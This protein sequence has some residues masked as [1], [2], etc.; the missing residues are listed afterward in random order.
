M[1]QKNNTTSD[2]ASTIS[3]M[4]GMGSDIEK[5]IS[6]LTGDG[7]EMDEITT[8]LQELGYSQTDLDDAYSNMRTKAQQRRAE[9]QRLQDMYDQS[10]VDSDGYTEDTIPDERMAQDGFETIDPVVP[11]VAGSG[12]LKGRK[13]LQKF[14]TPE[15]QASVNAGAGIGSIE[16]NFAN[17]GD[18][19]GLTEEQLSVIN[20]PDF[21]LNPTAYR[22]QVPGKFIRGQK[23]AGKAVA[24]SVGR[25]NLFPIKYPKGSANIETPEVDLYAES[26]PVTG[27]DYTSDVPTENQSGPRMKRQGA[28]NSAVNN[29]FANLA[30]NKGR[31]KRQ[32]SNRT[33]F[34]KRIKEGGENMYQFGGAPSYFTAD[35]FMSQLEDDGV[36]YG[37][38]YSQYLPMNL[39]SRSS[40]VHVA[41]FLASAIGGLFSGKDRDDDGLMDGF[42]RDIKA[43]KLKER[44]YYKDQRTSEEKGQDAL[45]YSRVDFD[46]ETGQYTGF[47][48]DKDPTK[49]LSK[50]RSIRE[51]ALEELNQGTPLGEFLAR[52]EDRPDLVQGILDYKKGVRSGDV[53]KGT[54]YG[55][56]ERGAEGYYTGENPYFYDT[57]MGLNPL[58]GAAPSGDKVDD[59]AD[60]EKL[61]FDLLELENAPKIDGCF[62]GNCDPDDQIE[63]LDYKP[64][65]ESANPNLPY[66]YKLDETSTSPTSTSTMNG[67][68]TG[69]DVT[70]LQEMY[71]DS[72]IDESK[73]TGFEKENAAMENRMRALQLMQTEAQGTMPNN[74]LLGNDPNA[75]RKYLA[76]MNYN[77]DV[78]LPSRGLGEEAVSNII[79]SKTYDDDPTNDNLEYLLGPLRYVAAGEGVPRKGAMLNAGQGFGDQT[80]TGFYGSDGR[81]IHD[82]SRY[83]MDFN[84]KRNINFINKFADK[85]QFEEDYANDPLFEY[86]EGRNLP[87]K[88][89]DGKEVDPP[90]KKAFELPGNLIEQTLFHYNNHAQ[91]LRELVYGNNFTTALNATSNFF[92]MGDTDMY[93]DY[94]KEYSDH[95][96]NRY[97]NLAESLGHLRSNYP[98]RY[99]KDYADYVKHFGKEAFQK[100]FFGTS[101]PTANKVVEMDWMKKMQNGGGPFDIDV[102]ALKQFMATYPD[103]NQLQEAFSTTGDYADYRGTGTGDAMDD[104]AEDTYNPYPLGP[105]TREE[106]KEAR[107]ERRENREEKLMNFRRKGNNFLDRMI[108]GRFGEGMAKLG[109]L[110]VGAANII[111]QAAENARASQAE[112]DIIAL[113]MSDRK[114]VEFGKDR[115]GTDIQGG[116]FGDIMAG[117]SP[118]GFTN[119]M[120]KHG[121]ELN[122]STDMIAKLIAAGADIEIK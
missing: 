99:A 82:A 102:N 80:A 64:I 61:E 41:P 32:Y 63:S 112:Q 113:G 13:R 65:R 101:T 118:D 7:Y 37:D 50:K 78:G 21:Q 111:N 90:S 95:E 67:V 10:V 115:T 117:D 75:I 69:D 42:F 97:K 120:S 94:A 87:I 76:Q 119:T 17:L 35:Q 40:P 98:D 74:P 57:M 72:F 6:E 49:Y 12:V 70:R 51:K 9:M 24:A 91:A 60:I 83:G 56:D 86:Y 105:E 71:P 110:G 48:T 43:K 33:Y 92:G 68:V 59:S 93:A 38:P 81:P 20:N 100:S 79:A 52:F 1:S 11:P 73:L 62:G 14:L 77:A 58:A 106:R 15:A 39:F 46:P 53:P 18:T 22:G 107:Q 31:G 96:R 3:T 55:I 8:A 104:A 85:L 114:G 88:Y 66:N 4:I 54:T 84:P 36:Y 34:N 116:L 2:L 26:L 23:K 109:T 25:P 16:G 29:F 89:K 27:Y 47:I 108:E 103:T 28:R 5:V 30:G 19:S 121:G 122:L 44:D 45:K